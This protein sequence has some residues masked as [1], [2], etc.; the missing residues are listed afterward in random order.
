[1]ALPW[2]ERNTANLLPHLGDWCCVQLH[3]ECDEGVRGSTIN[4]SSDLED[5]SAQCGELR[6][7]VCFSRADSFGPLID[8]NRER[9]GGK[10]R[11]V[12]QHP[13]LQGKVHE[14]SSK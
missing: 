14:M 10:R 1:M 12:C 4:T 2:A 11:E 13:T 3:V 9:E 6:I 7:E 5:V 8:T